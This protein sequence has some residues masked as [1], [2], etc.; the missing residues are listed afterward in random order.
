MKVYV[1]HNYGDNIFYVTPEAPADR[2]KELL[3]REV[4]QLLDGAW[5][6]VRMYNGSTVLTYEVAGGGCINI[7][8][9]GFETEDAAVPLSEVLDYIEG[10]LGENI[11]FRSK[12]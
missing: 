3:F 1:S 4:V 2:Y 5:I 7:R 8:F 10:I 11:S 6:V 9:D 12:S